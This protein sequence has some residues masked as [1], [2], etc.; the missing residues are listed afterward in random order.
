M[1]GPGGPDMEG[2]EQASDDDKI[3]DLEREAEMDS[4]PVRGRRRGRRLDS[5]Y[6][7][8]GVEGAGEDSEEAPLDELEPENIMDPEEE[9]RRR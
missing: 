1:G 2:I 9:A 3:E 7:E 6:N 5:D 8:D 4:L